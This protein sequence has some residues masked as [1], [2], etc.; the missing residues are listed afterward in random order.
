M[1]EFLRFILSELRGAVG[2]AIISAAV[3]LL[4][5]C[6]AAGV[7]GYVTRGNPEAKKFPLGRAASAALVFCW[8]AAI[9]YLTVMRPSG[10]GGS[11]N[12]HLF[13]A[14][15][16]AWNEFSFKAWSNVLLNVAMFVPLGVLLPLTHT[17]FRRWYAAAGVFFASTFAIEFTQIFAHRGMFDVDDLFAN[18]LGAVIGYGLSMS[19]LSWRGGG[20]G[21]TRLAFAFISVPLAAVLAIAGV[22][23]AYYIKPYG[24]LASAPSFY[25][26][27]GGVEWK[28]SCSLTDKAGTVAIYRA[29]KPDRDVCLNA[30]KDFFSLLGV[31]ESELDVGIYD[32]GVYVS[33]H[34]SA[35]I[36]V[37]YAD[38]S[39]RIELTRRASGETSN[40]EIGRDEA[41]LLLRRYGIEIPEG[42]AFESLGSGTYMFSITREGDGGRSGWLR[43][44]CENVGGE[45]MVKTIADH[46]CECVRVADED[47]ISPVE[48]LDLLERGRFDGKLFEFV[49][50]SNVE[51]TSCE[52]VFEA[53]TKGFYR[54]VYSFGLVCDGREEIRAAISAMK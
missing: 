29:V 46:I 50:P 24:N 11:A 49:S 28:V 44:R 34:K 1:N 23:A 33:D 20:E 38:G 45:V 25:A 37:Y 41:A 31:A 16:E 40:V 48:A 54:P 32:D 21:R 5:I 42:A 47:V 12:L 7:H 14:W 36:Y 13:R 2:F 10:Y 51:V 39:R 6:V 43:L 17:F 15:R 22:F 53:D 4:L 18:F 30:A 8:A 52:L 3:C 35:Y 27:V 26:D 19:A 9:I